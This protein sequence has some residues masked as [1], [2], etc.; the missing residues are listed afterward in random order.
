MLSF[1][2]VSGN[3]SGINPTI[4]PTNSTNTHKLHEKRGTQKPEMPENACSRCG[5]YSAAA[6]FYLLITPEKPLFQG[7]SGKKRSTTI[8]SK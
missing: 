7:L 1:Q 5:N 8:L 3:K 6:V 2:P 4:T